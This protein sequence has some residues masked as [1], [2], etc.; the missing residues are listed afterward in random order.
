MLA[1]GIYE[2][3]QKSQRRTRACAA[4]RDKT[5]AKQREKQR[6]HDVSENE[7]REVIAK[8]SWSSPEYRHFLMRANSSA[9]RTTRSQQEHETEGCDECDEEF[10]PIHKMSL[11]LILWTA[12]KPGSLHRKPRRR[13]DLKI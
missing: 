1:P 7:G 8:I 6:H 3:Y 11:L 9:S 2:R 4:C 13:V 5:R 12:N 10:C